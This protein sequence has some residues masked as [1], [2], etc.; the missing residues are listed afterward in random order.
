MNSNQQSYSKDSTRHNRILASKLAA[1]KGIL[2]LQKKL[3]QRHANGK[4]AKV[5]IL[6]QAGLLSSELEFSCSLHGSWKSNGTRVRDNMSFTCPACAKDAI[7]SRFAEAS[8]KKNSDEVTRLAEQHGFQILNPDSE[9]LKPFRAI[10]LK[11][12]T[13]FLLPKVAN[14]TSPLRRSCKECVSDR[15]ANRGQSRRKTR[16]ASI[17]LTDIQTS[18]GKLVDNLR[19]EENPEFKQNSRVSKFLVTCMLCGEDLSNSGWYHNLLGRN[20]SNKTNRVYC[21]ACNHSGPQLKSVFLQRFR[22]QFPEF[23]IKI[24]SLQANDRV[25]YGTPIQAYCQIHSKGISFKTG[26]RSSPYSLC[27]GCASEQLTLPERK[28]KNFLQSLGL[29]VEVHDRTQ[30]KPKEIDLWIPDRKIA[31]EVDGS[32][33][34][35][36]PGSAE[37]HL[38]KRDRCRELGI[39]LISFTDQQISSKPGLV[40]SMLRN[41]LGVS[42]HLTKLNARALSLGIPSVKEAREFADANH[43]SG[44]LPASHHLGLFRDGSLVCYLSAGRPR[45]RRK[46]DLEIYRF[47]SDRNTLVRGGFS[48]LLRELRRRNPAA[49]TILSYGDCRTSTGKVYEESGFLLQGFTRPSY[50]WSS[51][52]RTLKRYDTQKHKLE[53]LLEDFDPNSTEEQNMKANGYTQSF[54]YGNSVWVLDL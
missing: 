4:G 11:H 44:F 52:Q 5:T 28:L 40:K 1:S 21:P 49:R 30:L 38:F 15:I 9:P 25:C 43:L 33:W 14:A 32:Y 29:Q 20:H 46:E 12:G 10:C 17:H 50:T 34:H 42:S 48:R 54:D 36:L 6:T 3:D 27:A 53:N 23:L 35:S 51:G 18:I 31:V 19:I 16:L 7:T 47:C 13:K 22:R 37:T 39:R 2:S 24:P 41:R 8:A 26:D 45:F